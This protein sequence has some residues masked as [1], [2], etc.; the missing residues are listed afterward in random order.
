MKKIGARNIKTALAVTISYILVVLFTGESSFFAS[1]AA[2]ITMQNSLYSS[3]KAGKNRMIGTTIGVLV[4]IVACSL[5][6]N[7]YVQFLMLFLG[8]ICVIYCCNIFSFNQSVGIGC[9]VFTIITTNAGEIIPVQYGIIRLLE[10]FLGITVACIINYSIRPNESKDKLDGIYKNIL[11]QVDEIFMSILQNE[12][13]GILNNLRDEI[14]KYKSMMDSFQFG[15][16]DKSL[17]EEWEDR[18]DKIRILR[19]IN[20]HLKLLNEMKGRCCVSTDNLKRLNE[21]GYEMKLNACTFMPIDEHED[22][23]FNFHIDKMMRLNGELT[24]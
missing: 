4:A 20:V 10:T 12:D 13:N 21:L 7:M 19:E 17:K 5:S 18:N 14:T 11:T 22:I 16:E 1:I 2:V 3:F 23:V 24:L 8:V 6:V 15:H 9:I